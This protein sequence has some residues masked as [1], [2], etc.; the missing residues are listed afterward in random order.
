M[1]KVVLSLALAGTL[2]SCA[3]TKTGTAKTIDIV[4]SGVIHKPVIAD[5]NIQQ[6]KVS[7]TVTI[8]NIESL[9]VAKNQAI[10]ELIKE[11]NADLLVEPTYESSTQN[12]KTELTVYGWP[13]NYKNFRQ[14]EEKDIKFLEIKPNYLQKAETAQPAVQVK[15]GNGLLWGIL[16]AAALA[17]IV[18]AA[19][20]V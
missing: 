10:R 3:T 4:G 6:D 20:G 15:K 2:V 18:V 19:T 9:E 5:L 8:S 11:N 13:A 17:G 12:N 14:I 7:K 16:G 1:K